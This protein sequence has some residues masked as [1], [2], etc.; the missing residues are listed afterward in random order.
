M[1]LLVGKLIFLCLTEAM[2]LQ[3]A[4]VSL[5]SPLKE[6]EKGIFQLQPLWKESPAGGHVLHDMLHGRTI[7]G[8]LGWVRSIAFDPSNQWFCTGSVDRT[9]KGLL[10]N[11]G[12]AASTRHTYMFSAGDDKLVKCWDL[13]QNKGLE[14]VLDKAVKLED[15]GKTTLEIDQEN[16]S[17]G[18]RDALLL[19]RTLCKVM[20]EDNDEVTTKTR[21]FS[22][23]LLQ[24]LL[25]GVSHSFTNNFNITDFVKEMN[26]TGTFITGF[27][28]TIPTNLSVCNW[29]FCSVFVAFYLCKFDII[30]LFICINLRFMNYIV[31]VY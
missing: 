5:S 22:L 12:L 29:N 20:K 7:D 17:I 26:F 19:F 24:G 10:I 9:I 8:H 6:L 23:E 14:A 4:K 21:I 30:I 25:E 18:Q 15:G 27:N 11:A 28:F 1:F 16:M 3:S 13:E 31:M 2:V